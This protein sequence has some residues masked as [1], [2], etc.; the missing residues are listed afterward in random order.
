MG[1]IGPIAGRRRSSTGCPFSSASG[2]RRRQVCVDCGAGLLRV[3][4]PGRVHPGKASPLGRQAIGA[5]D[6]SIRTGLL[7]GATV[8]AV[9]GVDEELP[10]ALWVGRDAV[11]RTDGDARMV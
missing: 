8:D 2:R 6:G 9:G 11:D 4:V 1:L 3:G 7:A 5:E 10:V